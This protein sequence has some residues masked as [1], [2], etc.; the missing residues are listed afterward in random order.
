MRY[1]LIVISFLILSY[2]LSFGSEGVEEILREALIKYYNCDDV[3]IENLRFSAPL[4]SQAV[5]IKIEETPQGLTIFNIKM[6]DGK[7]IRANA[8]ITLL[9]KVVVSRRPLKRG[10][11]VT[12]EDLTSRLADLRRIPQGAFQEPHDITGKI[13]N[14]NLAPGVIITDGML[15]GKDS[16]KR[17]KKILIIAESLNF[18]I[19]VP[20]ELRENAVVGG[21][22]RAINLLTKKTVSGILI[23][24]N[25]MR[26]EF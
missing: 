24:E 19:S 15:A 21:Y 10:F 12:E 6:A 18:R 13:V 9:R 26:V 23:D 22:A 17:G 5:D 14:R 11:P 8:R 20:G 3:K 7:S 25:T 16:I 4:T 1:P 2:T